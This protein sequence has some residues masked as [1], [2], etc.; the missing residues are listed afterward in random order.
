MRAIRVHAFGGPEGLELDEVPTPSPKAGEVL[1]RVAAASVNPIDWKFREGLYPTLPLP[2]TIGGDF[3]GTIEAT[4]PGVSDFKIG[5][6]VFGTVPG[7]RG[8]QAEFVVVPSA[9]VALKPWTLDH[10]QAAS[11]PLSAVTAWQALFDNG[12]LAAG[13]HVLILGASGGVGS[14]AVQFARNAKAKVWATA[15]TRN[16]A[17]V[18]ELGADIVVI[19]YK[20]Q[21]LEDAVEDVDL[22][23][24]LVG[25]DFRQRAFDVVKKGGRLVTAVLPPP[26]Q[27]L[28]RARGI[29]ALHFF[30]HFQGDQLRE[31]ARQID[32]GRV[33]VSVAKV[34]PLERAGEAEE[35]NRKRQ[36]AGKIV[37]EVAA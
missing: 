31:I 18:R 15:S 12:K 35:L 13:E 4:G 2:F 14:L 30:E 6:D 36:V 26:D 16:V 7:S 8:S 28:A 9:A 11:V 27:E 24:D 5:D 21:R 25:G 34:L 32:A 20:K 1:V 10:I 29:T 33:R 37:L 17:G 3:S 19:D 22:C 23:V